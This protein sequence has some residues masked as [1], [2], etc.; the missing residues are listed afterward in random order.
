VYVAP[1]RKERAC[2]RGAAGLQASTKHFMQRLDACLELCY[3]FEHT[4]CCK[5]RLAVDA[6]R[7]LGLTSMCDLAL[8]CPE[9]DMSLLCSHP[10]RQMIVWRRSLPP[11]CSADICILP[12]AQG[13]MPRHE[14]KHR[15][16]VRR[17]QET[18]E[19]RVARRSHSSSTSCCCGQGRTLSDDD[20]Q[21]RSPSCSEQIAAECKHARPRPHLP[22]CRCC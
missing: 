11:V 9:P 17:R 2:V 5:M 10:G 8:R 1:H 4:I 19:R 20:E 16:A 15:R 22:T 3:M 6:S 18:D 21:Q 12:S 14:H 13:T 7:V